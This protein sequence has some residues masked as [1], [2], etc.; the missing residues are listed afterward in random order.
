[1]IL[2]V[3]FTILFAPGIYGIL[4]PKSSSANPM[5]FQVKPILL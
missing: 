5:L 3:F 1:M 4:D 2:N